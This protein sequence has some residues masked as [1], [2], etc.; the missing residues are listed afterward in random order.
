MAKKRGNKPKVS[1]LMPACNVEKYIEEC[2]NSV[3]AQT[4]E[5]IEII[6]IDDGSRD[7]TGE[8]LDKFKSR[9]SRIEV[10][11]KENTG[12]G[13]S[14]NVALEK[15]RGDY[16]GIVE[17]DDF[18]EPEM[19]EVM[20]NTAISNDA[21][22]VKT[23]YFDYYSQ[24]TPNNVK[25]RNLDIVNKYNEV[26]SPGENQNIFM[27]SPS[28]W[29]GI[30]RTEM[31]RENDI[32][33][34]ETPGASYQD[35]AFAFKIWACAD[36]IYLTEDAFLHYRRDNESSSVNSPH[37]VFCVCDEYN[38]IERF[39]LE[40]NKEKFL[41]IKYGV[42]FNTYRWNYR[43][44]GVEY[45]YAFL[46]KIIETYKDK[47]AKG[48][49]QK[50]CFKPTQ[51]EELGQIL[52]DAQTYFL[53]TSKKKMGNKESVAALLE[54]NKKLK[55]KIKRIRESKSFRIGKAIT[56]IPRKLHKKKW[57]CNI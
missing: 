8:I 53:S 12:Y 48:K 18:I 23:N 3:I 41:D 32:S 34:M 22:V 7:G 56:F 51:Y 10:I 20:Y 54:E 15:A 24:K 14:M 40:H 35:T 27:V 16:I 39:L 25:K 26:I 28:I 31:I 52:E 49:L 4:L 21:D 45:R 2:L 33:F 9:D 44:L 19:F 36:R 46:L 6:C 57:S 43:R 42:Q 11:H 38:E 55:K 30:Y 50:N 17:T 47:Y 1:I 5:E 29:S 13:H 37:K